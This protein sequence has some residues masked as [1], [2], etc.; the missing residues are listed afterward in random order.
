MEDPFD[1]FPSFFINMYHNHGLP[2]MD[3]FT[4]DSWPWNPE[5]D[6]SRVP[7]IARHCQ[8]RGS[9]HGGWDLESHRLFSGWENEEGGRWTCVH[10]V[11]SPFLPQTRLLLGV[12]RLSDWTYSIMP[13]SVIPNLPGYSW[14]CDISNIWTL[15][16][17]Q[18]SVRSCSFH[19]FMASLKDKHAASSISVYLKVSDPA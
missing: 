8:G 13:T 5:P 12:V 7:E 17:Q 1:S 18:I 19:S 11:L 16:R 6:L 4:K 15:P 14:V 3:C 10:C 9:P 2:F